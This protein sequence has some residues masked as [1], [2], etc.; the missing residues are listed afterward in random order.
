M[1]YKNNIMLE[2]LLL[3]IPRLSLLVMVIVCITMMMTI[4]DISEQSNNTAKAQ[5]D[6]VAKVA[7]QES[8][9]I[10]V[11]TGS[12]G[13]DIHVKHILQPSSEQTVLQLANV[14]KPAE[15]ITIST[16]SQKDA[17]AQSLTDAD[18][19][20]IMIPS[21][22]EKTTVEY[23]IKDALD[24]TGKIY[25]IQYSYPHTTVFL[26]PEHTDMV[27][28]NNRII[29]LEE[30]S[31]FACHGCNMMLEYSTKIP[32]YTRDIEIDDYMT[33]KTEITSHSEIKEIVFNS[34]T[35]RISFEIDDNIGYQFITVVIPTNLMNGPFTIWLDEEK[36]LY[37]KSVNDTHSSITMKLELDGMI[38]IEGVLAQHVVMQ[39]QQQ[40]QKM[41][42]SESQNNDMWLTIGLITSF[43]A[44]VAIIVIIIAKKKST[45]H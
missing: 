16:T 6:T 10:D 32:S 34:T 18:N 25:S 38:Y 21:S 37:Q 40:Q 9:T 2:S 27:F 7:S 28:V 43:A 11:G 17:S 19:G 8:I 26:T 14:G 1:K 35:N 44:A 23:D 13:L 41:Q 31:G 15:N 22:N 12:S 33:F 42:I 4:G 45:P 24:L 30:K 36:I 5:E 20:M 39:Q 29:Y 3:S